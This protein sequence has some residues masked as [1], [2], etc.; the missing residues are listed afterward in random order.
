MCFCELD[1]VN[2]KIHLNGKRRYPGIKYNHDVL[3][4]L[5]EAHGFKWSTEVDA[6][7]EPQ[8]D[9]LADELIRSLPTS[10]CPP[11]HKTHAA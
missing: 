11:E 1:I 6:L 10:H 8:L 3:S 5:A 2:V 7:P 9:R 4:A